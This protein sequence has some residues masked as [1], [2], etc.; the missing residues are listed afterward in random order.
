YGDGFNGRLASPRACCGTPGPGS[1]QAAHETVTC[2]GRVPDAV[3]D[4]RVGFARWA[5][6]LVAVAAPSLRVDAALVVVGVAHELREQ[7]PDL[8]LSHIIL[9]TQPIGYARGQRDGN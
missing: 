7:K 4:K 9:V 6:H 8:E 5:V 2:G 3:P 1:D